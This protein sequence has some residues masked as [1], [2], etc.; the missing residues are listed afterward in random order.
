ML[1]SLKRLCFSTSSFCCV[2]K[3]VPEKDLLCIM[4]PLDL[5]GEFLALHVR[6]R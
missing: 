4:K 2:K 5:M 1:N 6:A 3:L